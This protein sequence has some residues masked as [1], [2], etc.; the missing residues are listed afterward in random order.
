M[1]LT[2]YSLILLPFLMTSCEWFRNTITPT[3]TTPEF[4]TSPTTMTVAANIVDEAS[5][6]VDSRNIAGHVWVHEDGLNPN[7]I[8]L[9]NHK[10]QEIKKFELPMSNRDWEDLGIGPGP[11]D[12]VNY[13]YLADIG[14]NFEQW[15]EKFIYRFPEP[16]SINESIGNIDKITFKYSDGKYNAECILIDPATKDIYI[17]TKSDPKV[18]LNERLYRIPYPQSTAD[19][20]TA[21]FVRSIPYSIITGGSVSPDGKQIIVRSYFV[22]SYFIKKDTESFGDAIGRDSDLK[23]P[24]NFEPQGEAVAFDKDGK[25]YFTISEAGDGKSGTNLYYYGRKK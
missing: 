12:G 7:Q 15:E 17:I 4:E 2:K 3:S 1:K 14:D 10:G 5:G 25:G 11:Q 21:Q 6:I 19:V 18:R 13:L 9:L 8:H 23:L 20:Q 24:Y 16:K 22:L